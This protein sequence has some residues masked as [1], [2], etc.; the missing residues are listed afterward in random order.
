MVARAPRGRGHHHPPLGGGGG[1]HPRGAGRRGLQNAKRIKQARAITQAK[2]C[3]LTMGKE[4]SEG[5]RASLKGE[6]RE[7]KIKKIPFR[8][9]SSLNKK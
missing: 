9:K 7:R 4:G 3:S 5:L 2:L 6:S 1:Q 8:E